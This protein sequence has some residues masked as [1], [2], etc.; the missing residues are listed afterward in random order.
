MDVSKL[1]D[2]VYIRLVSKKLFYPQ[3]VHDLQSLENTCIHADSLQ[4]Q[5]TLC[6]SEGSVL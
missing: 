5:L 2:Q 4:I 6:A 1:L 3:S